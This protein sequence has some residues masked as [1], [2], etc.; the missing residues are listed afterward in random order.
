MKLCVQSVLAQPF[1][2]TKLLKMAR[3]VCIDR[4]IIYAYEHFGQNELVTKSP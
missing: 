3:F 1:V 2:N 4:W